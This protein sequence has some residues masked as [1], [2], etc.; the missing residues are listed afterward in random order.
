M[1]KILTVVSL[2]SI[3]LFARMIGGIAM[4]VDGEPITVSEI[5]RLYESEVKNGK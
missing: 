5:K 2:L 4:S 3:T 1:I